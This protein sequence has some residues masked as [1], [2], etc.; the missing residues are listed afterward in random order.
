MLLFRVWVSHSHLSHNFLCRPSHGRRSGAVAKTSA[1]GMNEQTLYT[2]IAKIINAIS[3]TVV[4]NADRFI[5]RSYSQKAL[6]FFLPQADSGYLFMFSSS[7][8]DTC[9]GNTF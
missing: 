3:I 5:H 7:C 8:Q 9:E 4:L 6:L 1:A 2:L